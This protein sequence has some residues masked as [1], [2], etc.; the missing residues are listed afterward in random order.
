MQLLVFRV[1]PCVVERVSALDPQETDCLREDAIAEAI[2]SAQGFARRER[3]VLAA[4]LHDAL[5]QPAG[6]ARH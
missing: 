3:A 5:G 1:G 6:K 2:D 4:V